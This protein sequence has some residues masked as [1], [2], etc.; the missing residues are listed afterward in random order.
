MR[1]SL[2]SSALNFSLDLSFLSN[3]F[4]P[5]EIG[6]RE[7]FFGPTSGLRSTLSKV[8]SSVTPKRLLGGLSKINEIRSHELMLHN[9]FPEGNL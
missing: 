7:S 1:L 5:K 3:N 4:K 2:I 8:L 6:G 9:Y